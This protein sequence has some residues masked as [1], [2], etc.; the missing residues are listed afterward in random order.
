MHS[1]DVRR[2]SAG[3]L[4]RPGPIGLAIRVIFGAASIYW[5]VAL[6]TKWNVFLDHD[7]IQSKRSYTLATL[8]LLPYVFNF[9]FRR[10]W[11]HGP[12]SSLWRPERRSGSPSHSC[13]ASSGM[14]SKFPGWGF[15]RRARE[16]AS[17]GS[18]H[19]GGGPSLCPTDG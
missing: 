7:P 14:R 5:L 16:R 2:D 4:A 15:E 17:N 11:A 9:T 18:L 3:E 19:I 8:W 13:P 12:P 10:R 1:T 6:L